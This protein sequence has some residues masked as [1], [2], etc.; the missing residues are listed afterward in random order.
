MRISCG[1]PVRER[2]KGRRRCMCGWHH[3]VAFGVVVCCVLCVVC[4]LCAF[5][6]VCCACVLVCLC[7][8]TAAAGLGACKSLLLPTNISSTSTGANLSIISPTFPHQQPLTLTLT[9]TPR[10]LR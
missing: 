2:G 6:V 8:V 7:V 3:G 10:T 1:A 4:A 9:L 5:C